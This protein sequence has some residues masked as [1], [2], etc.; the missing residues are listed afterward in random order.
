MLEK[1]KE[2]A[3]T[4]VKPPV[5]QNNIVKE[6]IVEKPTIV[7]ETVIQT[8]HEEFDPN[9]LYAE[10]GYLHDRLDKLPLPDVQEPF[11]PKEL[12]DQMRS[13][14][15]ERFKENIDMLGMPDFRKLAMGIQAQVDQKVT[16]VSDSGYVPT[17]YVQAHEPPNPRTNDLW[18]DTDGVAVDGITTVTGNYAIQLAD[19]TVVMSSAST[20]TLP[21]G[22]TGKS[23]HIKNLSDG[24]VTVV[25][26]GGDT[27]D[28]ETTQFLPSYSAM[29]VQFNGDQYII[30]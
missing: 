16:G 13:E 28:G 7:K 6:T 2:I 22:V 5:I 15:A 26:S 27:I 17:L 19:N 3:E 9:P 4:V 30:L 12:L 18:I 8:V 24:T 21:V 11:D 1:A 25:V 20:A 10:I 14:F 29:H 23:F